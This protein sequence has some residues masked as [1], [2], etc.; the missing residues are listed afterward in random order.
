MFRRILLGTAILLAVVGL[1]SWLLRAAP[2]A[3]AP[4]TGSPAPAASA[5]PLP[6]APGSG[7]GD[8]R[9]QQPSAPGAQDARETPEQLGV[10]AQIDRLDTLVDTDPEQAVR[11]ARGLLADGNKEVRLRAV[12]VLD[13]VDDD[14]TVDS[15]AQALRD[16]EPEVRIAAAE[17]LANHPERRSIEPLQAALQSERDEEVRDELKNAL[18]LLGVD[19][20]Q[21]G[22]N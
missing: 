9:P 22:S 14:T 12:E 8:V 19:T 7:A 21:A 18:E 10:E 20:E 2:E 11:V 5:S 1:A 4:A 17:A 13:D 15:L 3:T 6:K 16:P